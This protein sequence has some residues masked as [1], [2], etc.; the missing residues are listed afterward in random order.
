MRKNN[1]NQWF[2]HG[3]SVVT[4]TAQRVAAWHGV[5]IFP[6]FE[7]ADMRKTSE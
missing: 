1:I 7:A 4:Y 5:R 3:Y 6:E 2:S